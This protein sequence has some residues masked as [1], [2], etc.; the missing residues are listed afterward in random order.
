[1]T[2]QEKIKLTALFEELWEVPSDERE[3][4]IFEEVKKIS[5]DPKWSD[6]IYWSDEFVNEDESLNIP[7][8]IKKLEEHKPIIFYGTENG[9]IKKEEDNGKV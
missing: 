4:E 1:M 6:Y 5:P 2:E 3:I 9:L 7:K 8:L